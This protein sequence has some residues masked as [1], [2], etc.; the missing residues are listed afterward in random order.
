MRVDRRVWAALVLGALAW[1]VGN[2]PATE[3][4][5]GP[6]ERTIPFNIVFDDSCDGMD[7][8]LTDRQTVFGRHTGCNAGEFVRGTQFNVD[9]ETGFSVQ[10]RDN[11][12]GLKVQFDV[13]QT[14]FRAGRFYVFDVRSNQLLR[15]STYSPAPI[16]D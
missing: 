9:G 15:F 10:F 12:S 13:Y 3:S 14:G 11:V 16:E 6:T 1:G 7:V 2:G 5:A 4:A 8:R